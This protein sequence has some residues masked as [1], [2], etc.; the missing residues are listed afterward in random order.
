MNLLLFES[1]IKFR[2]LDVIDIVLVALLMFQFYNIVRGTAAIRIFVGI[3]VIYIF[4]KIV[5]VLKMELLKEILGQFIGVGVLA[6]IIVFQQEIRKF[7]IL[8]GT[9]GFREMPFFKKLFNPASLSNY[10]INISSIAKACRNMASSKTGALIVIAKTSDVQLH[11]TSGES[12]DSNYS[13]RIIESIFFKN[14]PLHDGGILIEGDKI[15]MA[16]CVLPV[17]EKEDFPARL[18]M[19]HRAALGITERSDAL[20]IVVS[21][22]TGDIAVALGGMI[23]TRLN[24]D[25]LLELLNK[26]FEMKGTKTTA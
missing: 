3:L 16:R 8:I 20:A 13:S 14:N 5:A 11:I 21:E 6:I 26:E 15:K 12:L 7:L 1:F 23:N 24:Y 10:H 9:T 2:W 4:W 19:R 17:T 18:G 25:E 22:Q